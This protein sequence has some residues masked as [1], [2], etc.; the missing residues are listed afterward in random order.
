MVMIIQ[1]VIIW[2]MEYIRYGPH[3][4]KQYL[5]HEVIRRN[6]LSKHKKRVE[7]AESAF[8]VLQ[9]HFAIVR[10]SACLWDDDSLGNIMIVED[11]SEEG[12]DFNYDEMR[13]KVT[14]SHDDAPEIEAFIANYRKIKDNETHTQLQEDLIEHSWKNYPDLYNSITTE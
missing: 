14:V 10:G 2:Q 8:G 1:W 7:D 13:E 4:W 11:E 3:L 6:I 9:S 5:S 12:N